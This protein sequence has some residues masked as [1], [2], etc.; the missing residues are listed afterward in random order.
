MF[1]QGTVSAVGRYLCSY[2]K[3]VTCKVFRLA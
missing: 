2:A 3:F 1:E